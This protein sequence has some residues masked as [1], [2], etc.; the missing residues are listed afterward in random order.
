MS[1]V[2]CPGQ[3]PSDFDVPTKHCSKCKQVLPLDSFYVKDKH[4]G[5]RMSQC[6]RCYIER[7]NHPDRFL[8]ERAATLAATFTPTLRCRTCGLEKDRTAFRRH[9]RSCKECQ[10]PTPEK[11][12]KYQEAYQERHKEEL[13]RRRKDRYDNDAR[14][15]VEKKRLWQRANRKKCVEYTLRYRKKNPETARAAYRR[16]KARLMGA[17]GS[18]TAKE[19]IALKVSYGFQCLCCGR[20]EPEICLTF[21]HVIPLSRGG[22]NGIANGQPLCQSCNSSKGNRTIDYRTH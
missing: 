14:Y 12:K 18:H 22:S 8:D 20:Q 3:I 4:T 13:R 7:N 17:A 5:R 11:Q 19:W 10:Q 6:K 9:R 21:D 15:G 2:P 16:W 1:T